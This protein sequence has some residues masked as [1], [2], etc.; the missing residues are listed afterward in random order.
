M[1]MGRQYL[2]MRKNVNVKYPKTI[3]FVR[4]TLNMGDPKRMMKPTSYGP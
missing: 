2:S 1:Y 3:V 4:T